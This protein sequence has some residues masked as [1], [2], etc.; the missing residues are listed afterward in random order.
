MDNKLLL[1]YA[2]FSRDWSVIRGNI[3]LEDLAIFK[4][5]GGNLLETLGGNGDIL[6]LPPCL[7]GEEGLFYK[8]KELCSRTIQL[9]TENDSLCLVPKKYLTKENLCA[10]NS[11]FGYTTFH[12]AARHGCLNDIPTYF[13]CESNF[14]AKANKD[15]TPL[16]LAV[17]MVIALRKCEDSNVQDK[18]KKV[19]QGINLILS[20]L[21][22]KTLQAIKTWY[23][24][25]E[26][27]GY[28]D[29]EIT[30][31]TLIKNLQKGE[32]DIEI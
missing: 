6:K 27:L 25:K 21:R 12:Y 7:I 11:K 9:L 17:G 15:Q 2:T 5:K 4:E 30:K 16:E 3:T 14:M 20:H 19:K 8:D 26:I 13:H 23:V 24:D 18:V 32:K 22:D 31:R 1:E 28:I 10:K 29:T